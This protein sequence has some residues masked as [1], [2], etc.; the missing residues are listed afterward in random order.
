VAL[1]VS[2]S[3]L[4]ESGL[5][6]LV[7]L[8]AA[9]P[10][11]VVTV[12]Q[13]GRLDL[14]HAVR[15]HHLDVPLAFAAVLALTRARRRRTVA[16]WLAVALGGLAV[17]AWAAHPTWHGAEV[18]ARAG[19]GALLVGAAA[20]AGWA[21][22]A[23]AAFAGLGVVE[24]AWAAVQTVQRPPGPDAL[25]GATGARGT[26]LARNNL[27]GAAVVLGWWLLAYG[28][29]RRSRA[30]LAAGAVCL[31]PVGF[32]FSRS[33]LLG[34]LLAGAVV[35][36]AAV[37]DPRRWLPC[38]LAVL[39]GFGVTATLRA[40][41]WLTR[42]RDVTGGVTPDAV[43]NGRAAGSRTALD[44]VRDH[45][46]LGVGPGRYVVAL[47][48]EDPGGPA[49]RLPVHSVPLL[50]AA[51]AGLP[52][53]ALLV[54]LLVL[55][56]VRSARAGPLALAAFLAYLPFVLLDAFPLTD[57]QG[58][59]TTALWLGLLRLLAAEERA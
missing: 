1:N 54:A 49:D 9:A 33:A 18:L 24:L 2:D 12:A 7:V 52:A 6:A 47:E 40:D 46:L 20:R 59:V 3:R 22:P 45:P 27:A 5:V 11:A 30:H 25:P 51:E 16:A 19:L 14:T 50:V 35:A 13:Y 44:L 23:R 36:A 58:L 37:R 55:L 56:A 42:A 34:L 26:F 21:W 43:S 29:R 53:A 38:A 32:T 39:L 31:A 41:G 8:A 15:L 48:T 10:A 28:V 57:A 17:A 4:P